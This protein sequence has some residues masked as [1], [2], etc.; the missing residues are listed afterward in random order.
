MLTLSQKQLQR[1]KVIEKAV[2]GR[3]IAAQAGELLGLSERQI[4]RLKRRY[5]PDQVDWVYHGNRGRQPANAIPATARQQVVRLAAG[6]YGGFNDTHLHE[7][8]VRE[9]GFQMSRPTL[10]RILR[11]AGLA[12]PQK[13]RAPKYRSRRERREQRGMLLQVDGSRHDWLEGRGP[14]LTLLGFIDD[15]DGEVPLAEFQE[16]HEDSAGYLRLLRRLVQQEGIPLAL[17]RDQHGTFQRNDDHWSLEE[18]LQGYQFPTQLGRAL[19][20]LGIQAIVARSPQAKGRIERLWRTFQDRLGSELRLAGARTVEQANALLTRFL[21][22]FNAAFRKLPRRPGSAYRK[23]DPHLDLD[24]ICSFRYPRTVGNDHVIPALPGVPVQ[25]PPLARNRGYAG[26]KVEVCQQPSGDL[27]IYLQGRLLQ[28]VSAP[29]H[30]PPV[31]AHSSKR[32]SAAHQQ[33]CRIYNY[34]G[35]PALAIAP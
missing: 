34:A 11:A 17:Y 20:E 18:Q 29:P 28:R 32:R 15:A 33:P 16:T 1:L 26:R 8:L 7:K 24:Y 25:L 3:M 4:Q 12:S 21:P 13:R 5:Q 23:L 2:E 30:A 10:R 35:R 9:E 31:R 19:Q 14:F 6:K 27:L 22:P